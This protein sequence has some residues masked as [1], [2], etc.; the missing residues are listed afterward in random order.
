MHYSHSHSLVHTHTLAHMHALTHMHALVHTLTLVHTH[1][2]AHTLTHQPTLD[3]LLAFNQKSHRWSRLRWFFEKV[4]IFINWFNWS[5]FI[6]AVHHL[7]GRRQIS[8]AFRLTKNYAY[9]RI[10][11]AERQPRD[12]L[13]FIY[14][15]SL[16]QCLKSIGYNTLSHKMMMIGGLTKIHE[17]V[18]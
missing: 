4:S 12:P 1:K 3:V 8:I 10:A 5:K 18:P 17:S 7:N 6:N 9:L 14:F 15:L 2:H 16:M 11:Q 13:V